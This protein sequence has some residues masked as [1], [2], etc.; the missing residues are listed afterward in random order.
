MVC[1]IKISQ[2]KEKS[3]LSARWP[4]LGPGLIMGISHR[5]AKIGCLRYI[6][7]KTLK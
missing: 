4:Q 6:G 3:I 5:S 1:R 7:N 2:L